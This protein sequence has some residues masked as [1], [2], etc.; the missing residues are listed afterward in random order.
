MKV[1]LLSKSFQQNSSYSRR[2]IGEHQSPC[3]GVHSSYVRNG[4]S[5]PFPELQCTYPPFPSFLSR[6][7][8]VLP[9]CNLRQS[10]CLL[11]WLW[12]W[13]NCQ[14]LTHLVAIL[15][16]WC[17]SHLT[18]PPRVSTL[19]GHFALE[20]WC[21]GWWAVLAGLH[22]LA[23]RLQPVMSSRQLAPPLVSSHSSPS[24]LSFPSK[25]IFFSHFFL[26][27]LLL[28]LAHIL[29]PSKNFD[30]RFIHPVGQPHVHLIL[31]FCLFPIFPF[32]LFLQNSR[33]IGQLSPN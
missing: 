27:L 29:F 1:I 4:F 21:C 14:P 23:G 13:F 24:S 33:E 16:L 17:W 30:I 28:S 10:G 19:G 26:S 25:L 12:C 8:T 11:P 5:F 32:F 15:L 31:H 9:L 6:L 3:P 7:L 2:A 22:W 18:V 20:A